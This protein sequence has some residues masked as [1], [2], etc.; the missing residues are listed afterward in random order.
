MNRIMVITQN[1]TIIPDRIPM[2]I[3]I[4]DA[5]DVR[6]ELSFGILQNSSM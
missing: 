4:Q 1:R 2:T 6:M 3:G 5:I